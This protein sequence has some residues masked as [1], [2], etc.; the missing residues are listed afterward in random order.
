MTAK[1]N[2]R[3]LEDKLW[4]K[5]RELAFLIYPTDCYTCPAKNLEGVN[6]Q[7][8]HM[9]AKGALSA[10]L[11]YD[12]RVLRWQCYRCNIHH[13]GMGA[14]FYARMLKEKGKKYMQDLEKERQILV[15]AD[16]IFYQQKIDEIQKQIDLSTAK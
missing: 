3:K 15:K 4:K 10:H 5:C 7:L 16:E 8:G 6:C 9:W 13:G 1:S 12:M 14:V 2:K 11:K